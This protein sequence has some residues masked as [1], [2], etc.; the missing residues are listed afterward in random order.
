M[1]KFKDIFFIE[2]ERRE[3]ARGSPNGKN[4][5]DLLPQHIDH[6]NAENFAEA[7]LERLI[8]HASK[9]LDEIDRQ[10]EREFK[11]YEMRKEFERR[12]KLAVNI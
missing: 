6:Q 10:R 3:L 9:D 1:K 12:S 11:D 2:K 7:D 8:R 5:K 4:I